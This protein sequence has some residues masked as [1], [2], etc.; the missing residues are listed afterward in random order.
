MDESDS[1]RIPDPQSEPVISESESPQ[2]RLAKFLCS[3]GGSVLPRPLDGRLRYVGGETRI[4]TVPFTISYSSLLQKMRETFEGAD[5]IKYQQPD[6]DLDALVS[7][8]N[9]DDVINMMDEYDKLI[10]CGEAFTRLRIFLFSQFHLE[11]EIDSPIF[12]EVS[13][14][15]GERR[16]VDALNS[17]TDP[18]TGLNSPDTEINTAGNLSLRH[19]NVPISVYGQRFSDV[20][21]PWSAGYLSPNPFRDHSAPVSPSTVKFQE[22]LNDQ[23]LA[24]WL[25]PGG[26]AVQ[27][28]LGFPCNLADVNGNFCEHCHV[29]YRQCVAPPI[30]PPHRYYAGQTGHFHGGINNNH[31]ADCYHHNHNNNGG[32]N[33]YNDH[34]GHDNRMWGPPPAHHNQFN[35]WYEDP[36][37]HRAPVPVPVPVP[38]PYIPD[39]NRVNYQY[40]HVN[41]HNTNNHAFG[42]EAHKNEMFHTIT[43]QQHHQQQVDVNNLES[44]Y[45]VPQNLPPIPS[46]RSKMQMQQQVHMAGLNGVN[47]INPQYIRNTPDGTPNGGIINPQFIRNTPDGTPN[48][49]DVI[50]PQYIRNTPDGT[51]NGV[52]VINPPQFIRNTPDGTPNGANVI[53]PQFIRNTPD[54]TPNGV[55]GLNPLFIPNVGIKSGFM[56]GTP[57]GSPMPS[58][59][60]PYD[61][62][63]QNPI[64]VSVGFADKIPNLDGP[65]TEYG[66]SRLNPNNAQPAPLQCQPVMDTPLLTVGARLSGKAVDQV[67]C[68]EKEKVVVESTDR[69]VRENGDACKEGNGG[70]VEAVKKVS[71]GEEEKA[72]EEG[73]TEKKE[74]VKEG[75][76]NEE[77]INKEEVA[78]KEGGGNEEKT[79]VGESDLHGA[80]HENGNADLEAETEAHDEQEDNSKIEP[81]SAEQ[82][83]HDKGLQ[84]IKNED[85]EE[86]KELGSGTY[87]SVFHGKWRGSDVAIKR[88]KASCFKG[89]PSERAK[90]IADF[91][92]EALT[93]SSLHHPNV[94]SFYGVV[95]DGPDNS[96]A[97]V[98]EF[99]VNGSLKQF[100]HKKDRTIDRRK[101][102]IIA[103]DAA[104]GME[105][106]HGKNIV[107]F[108]LKCENLLVNM[109]DPHRP[110]CKIGDLGLSKVKQHTLV[111]GGVRGTLPWMAPELL[112][113]K[114][115]MVSEK[116]DVYS[117]GI[118]MWELLTGEEPYAEMRAASIIGGLLNNSLRP[119]IPT[120]CD[121][122]WKGLMES[123]WDSDPTQRPS[124]SEISQK[125]RKMAAA[126]NVK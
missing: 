103:M 87:G 126:I 30:D 68:K 24:S 111:S 114:C 86:I 49:V 55:N 39:G 84:T 82:E 108:D 1:P 119:Q 96:L 62:I 59:V 73:K 77:K 10:S 19:L 102:L 16:Y 99:M 50:N 37:T 36:R 80:E 94:V 67:E 41:T 14:R 109:R 11:S 74:S 40:P 3:F 42:T 97:T 45:Q 25:P 60:G 27:E 23:G 57:D 32:N 18:K 93:L 83:A 112:S 69:E 6:E 22:D 52:N 113:G 92:K 71:L 17:S 46:L 81:T 8:V 26:T 78:L 7:V 5:V 48:G 75:G 101:R 15:D 105:Y 61:R 4:I 54:G 95:R 44:L 110:I 116:I 47:I 58:P 76:G 51:P 53:N 28:K 100:L 115:N 123:C 34:H 120:W 2:P 118:C 33:Y 91:W 70:L 13:E 125:L 29:A 65:Q 20:D 124:F 56:I 104:F 72:L 89:R 64:P 63:P 9:D 98:T 106:L 35:Y 85:L 31:C 107:H 66:G 21:S 117:F 12:D 90:L 43:Q 88:I 79:N 121:P 122:E 38:D